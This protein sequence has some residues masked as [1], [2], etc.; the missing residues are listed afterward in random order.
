MVCLADEPISRLS[1]LVNGRIVYGLGTFHTT[2]IQK[3]V[4]GMEITVQ[5]LR[6]K[7]AK[8]A[9]LWVRALAALMHVVV[10]VARAPECAFNGG[11]RRQEAYNTIMPST[12]AFY[13]RI[14]LVEVETHPDG[15]TIVTVGSPSNWRTWKRFH[16]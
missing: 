13:G 12:V 10:A 11:L 4:I 1:C 14:L 2:I 16:M 5:D 8:T 9:P 3:E 15:I 6:L 7:G